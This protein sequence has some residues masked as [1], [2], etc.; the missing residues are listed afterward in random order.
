M[1]V[2][3][4]GLVCIALA[5][6]CAWTVLQISPQSSLFVTGRTSML[7]RL[8]LPDSLNFLEDR[9]VVVVVSLVVTFTIWATFR[10]PGSR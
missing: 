8:P 1:G 7:S 2:P 4:F 6:F 3:W 5:F 9:S 10:R